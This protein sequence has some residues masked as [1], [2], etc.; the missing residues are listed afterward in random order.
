MEGYGKSITDKCIEIIKYCLDNNPLKDDYLAYFLWGF[1]L[2][3][4][5]N[6]NDAIVKYENA[7]NKNPKFKEAY[8][9][10][11]VILHNQNEYSQAI[12]NFNKAYKYGLEDATL[13]AAITYSNWGTSLTE[14]GKYEDAIT[15]FELA[16]IHDQNSSV[17]Y[18]NWGEALYRLARYDDAILM[19]QKSIDLD[20]R[21]GTYYNMG[22]AYHDKQDYKNAIN[23]YK[24]TINLY[25]DYYLGIIYSTIDKH[26]DYNKAIRMFEKTIKLRPEKVEAY[27]KLFNIF[28]EQGKL[29]RE[30]KMLLKAIRLCDIFDNQG[31]LLRENK[32]LIKDIRSDLQLEIKKI[33]QNKHLLNRQSQ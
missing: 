18:N 14:E 11:A 13:L 21:A 33:K 27:D 24:K 8:Y 10:L 22:L 5:N 29:A 16:V 1:I 2:D 15:K 9:K 12:Q 32:K 19:Y 28:E 25:P 30:Y 6:P 7:I 17:A 31:K 23:I 4:Q 3:E 20:P 26:K